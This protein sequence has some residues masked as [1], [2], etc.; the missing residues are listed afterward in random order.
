MSTFRITWI[1]YKDN[2]NWLQLNSIKYKET[3]TRGIKRQTAI[4]KTLDDSIQRQIIHS[5]E[6][7][8]ICRQ[9]SSPAQTICPEY[10]AGWCARSG[11]RIS[12]ESRE[13][14]DEAASFSATSVGFIGLE[15]FRGKR[16]VKRWVARFTGF[17]R[18]YDGSVSSRFML[19]WRVRWLLVRLITFCGATAP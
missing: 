8:S 16:P 19:R 14:L 10:K 12:T 17:D 4:A 1:I 18:V 15:I 9:T 11:S 2:L 13:Y 6:I 3:N 7:H 5:K